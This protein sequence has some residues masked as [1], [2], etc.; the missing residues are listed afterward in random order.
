MN[1]DSTVDFFKDIRISSFQKYQLAF[2]YIFDRVFALVLLIILLPVFLI[3]SVCIYLDDGWPIFFIQLRVGLHGRPF[4]MLKFRTFKILQQDGSIHTYKGDPRITRV[5]RFLRETSL[6][7]LPQLIN[8]ILGHMSFIGPRP[9][10]PEQY[11]QLNDIQKKRTLVKPGIT[12][13]AQINGRNTIPW[14]Q[15]IIYDLT[16]IKN[17]SLLL[18]VYIIIRTIFVVIKREGVWEKK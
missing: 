9:N 14:E 2:K 15:R 13:L 7:E 18:D 17:Y 12:G 5:G 3:I 4:K 6:D 1:H 16:Y 11:Q 10:L 8:I